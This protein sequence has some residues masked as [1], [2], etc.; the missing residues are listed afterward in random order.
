RERTLLHERGTLRSA[1]GGAE[2]DALVP[3]A[4]AR[5]ALVPEA[6]ARDALVAVDSGVVARDSVVVVARDSAVGVPVATDSAGA[7][8]AV[9]DTVEYLP[10]LTT[11]RDT[12]GKRLPGA[13][14]QYADIGVMVRGRGE[15]GGQWN[16]YNPCDQSIHL[17][18]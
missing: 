16:R 4:R 3:E 11:H 5:D 7:L 2:R 8:A 1:W 17:N 15:L 12:L 6:R 14:G 9:S 13:M 18:C 10:L